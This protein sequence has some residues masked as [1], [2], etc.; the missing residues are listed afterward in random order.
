MRTRFKY[1]LPI[2]DLRNDYEMKNLVIIDTLQRLEDHTAREELVSK[3]NNNNIKLKQLFYFMV[4]TLDIT[5][6]LFDRTPDE[7]REHVVKSIQLEIDSIIQSKSNLTEDK[8]I[9]I[10]VH[11]ID[12]EVMNEL[13]T[14]YINYKAQE[15]KE[16]AL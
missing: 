2:L 16:G 7:I 1:A 11:D 12:L 6:K 4:F 8:K 3:Y 13:K 10:E 5:T 15:E 9:A 14:L